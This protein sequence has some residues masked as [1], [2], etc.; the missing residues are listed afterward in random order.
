MNKFTYLKSLLLLCALIVGAGTSWAADE[1]IK[2]SELYNSN[3]DM[4]TVN[5]TNFTITFAKG[6]GSNVP[7]YYTNG[8]AVRAYAGNTMTV[9]SMTKTIEKIEIGF[10]SSDGSNAITTDVGT[11]SNGT[12]TGNATSV[13]FTVGGTSGHRRIASVAVTYVDESK[14]NVTLSFPEDSYDADINDSFT[15]PTLTNTQNVTVTYASS[16]ATVATVNEETG[17]VTLVGVGTTT[18]TASFAGNDT[19]NSASASYTLVV[20]NRNANDGSLEKPY[21]ASEAYDIIKAFTSNTATTENY[22]VKGIVSGFYGSNESVLTDSYNRYYISKDGSDTKQILVFKGNGLNNKAFSET[23]N[24]AIGD[25]VVIYGPFQLYNGTAEISTGNYI[26]SKTADERQEAGISYETTEFTVNIG[27]VGDFTAPTLTNPNNVTVTYSSS[28]EN[29]AIVDE[30]TGEVLLGSAEGTVTITATFA[31]DENYKAATASY[32]ITIKDPDKKEKGSFENPYTVAEVI[33]GTA[34]GEGIYVKGYIVG[35]YVGKTTNPR[36]SGFTTDAN[37]AIAGEFTTSPTASASIP[38]ALPTQ[39]LKDT[40]GNKTTNGALLGYE[41]ILKGDKDTYFTVNGIK[42]TTEVTALSVPA[43]VKEAG[44]ATW[45][46]PFNVEVP[47]S[48]EAYY[49]S[50]ADTKAT[51]SEVLTI[52]AGEPV[53]LKN[54]GT[55]R[56]QVIKADKLVEADF[57]NL[58][59]CD[60]GIAINDYVLA[61]PTGKEVGFYK[62]AGTVDLPANQVYL[63]ASS[64][65]AEFDFIGFEGDGISTGIEAVEQ[66]TVD[67]VYYNLAGQRVAQPAKG[68]YIVNGKKV[69][70]K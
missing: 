36:T 7:K 13:K 47:A 9:A 3:T 62:W 35:E 11:Y 61:A 32:T 49:V 68:L 48:V 55:Y 66:T 57:S 37:T 29:L 45:V 23:N 25:E 44:Y 52:P 8:T 31:G 42:N 12:W 16:K 40:W 6:T 33:D 53:V 60:G 34:T 4:G 65:A 22:Y 17:A 64:L 18:I 51:L 27:E 70:L 50:N 14:Q 69:I 30:T 58:L 19:Y 46:A 59:K 67:G 15:A 24:I 38:V 43:T 26:Y 28:D 56:F 39:G 1:T 63:P 54:E 41:V 21:T 20:K 5:G 10:G 2:F